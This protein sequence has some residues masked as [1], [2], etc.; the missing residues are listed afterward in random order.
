MNQPLLEYHY[1]CPKKAFSHTVLLSIV[2]WLATLISCNQNKSHESNTKPNDSIEYNRLIQKVDT[3]T[4]QYKLDSAYSILLKI[5]EWA[6]KS[7]DSILIARSLVQLGNVNRSNVKM[8]IAEKHLDEAI[9]ILRRH[10]KPELLAEAL[11]N[12]GLVKQLQADYQ[13]SQQLLFESLKIAEA[14]KNFERMSLLLNLIGSNLDIT[15]NKSQAISYFQR[16]FHLAERY[17]F[18]KAKCSI[19][20]NLG[21]AYRHNHPDSAKYYYLKVINSHSLPKD[22]LRRIQAVFNLGN[23]YLDEGN[24]N[25]AMLAYQQVQSFSIQQKFQEGIAISVNGIASVYAR[26]GR[27]M[28]AIKLLNE[29]IRHFQE[30]GNMSIIVQLKQN[31]IEYYRKQSN[32]KEIDKL[33]SSIM[34]LQDSLMNANR[35]ANIQTLEFFYQNKKKELENKQLATE[36]RFAR[37]SGVFWSVIFLVVS[38]CSGGMLLYYKKNLKEKNQSLKDLEEWVRV[39]EKL[40]QS[41]AQQSQILEKQIEEKQ[42]ELS[43]LSRQLKLLQDEIVISPKGSNTATKNTISP[44]EETTPQK[45]KNY[46]ENLTMKFNIIYPG[47]T[48]KLISSYP[49]LNSNDIQFCLL[50]KLNLPIKDIANILNVSQYSLYKRK[51]RLAEKIKLYGE[52][53]DLYSAIQNIK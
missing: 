28:E 42:Q 38:C 35:Q 6:L 2:V 15:G 32:Y 17:N 16:A 12:A 46:W 19:Y 5:H 10:N 22:D 51:S 48:D 29:A 41:K 4:S 25:K 13:T 45:G 9:A 7:N 20:T 43:M 36:L 18:E 30:T 40:R 49:N 37:L 27:I 26:Q 52:E 14:H 53:R 47:F 34:Q 21:V 1:M 50:I 8:I 11:G 44:I 3:L 23:V 31:I 33:Y 39:Q 24:Y